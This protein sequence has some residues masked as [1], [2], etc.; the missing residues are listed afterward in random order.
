MLLCRQFACLAAKPAL[1]A[2]AAVA[3]STRPSGKDVLCRILTVRAPTPAQHHRCAIEGTSV[4]IAH[5]DDELAAI[6]IGK[7]IRGHVRKAS[8]CSPAGRLGVGKVQT[9]LIEERCLAIRG[10]NEK[11][12]HEAS[13]HCMPDG[14]EGHANS[15]R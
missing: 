7:A 1:A 10:V 15:S 14:S 12:R 4:V 3:G 13:I 5:A 2:L 9:L 6:A 11:T 8:Q